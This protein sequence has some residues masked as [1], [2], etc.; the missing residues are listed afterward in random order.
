M[1]TLLTKAEV[2]TGQDESTSTKLKVV[3][4][5]RSCVHDGAGL[6][7][8]IFF[9]G[10][11]LRCLWC[12][13]PEA[14]SLKSNDGDMNISIESIAEIILR[15]KKY[16][17]VSGG[18]VTLSGG[19]P[20]LQDGE[21]LKNLLRLL[22]E[23][24]IHISAETALHAPWE[25]ISAVMPY[26]DTFIVD[27]KAVGSDEFHKSLTG[28]DG[29]LIRSN[30]EKLLSS[31]AKIKIRML[32]VPELNDSEEHIKNAASYIKSLGFN[33]IELM[34]YHSMYENKAHTFG[35]DIPM[36]NITPGQSLISLKNGVELFKKYAVDAYSDDLM[37]SPA[38][39]ELAVRDTAT[40]GN[41]SRMRCRSSRK[42]RHRQGSSSDARTT[43]EDTGT[44]TAVT[45]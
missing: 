3:R 1:K 11:G 36:L 29:V 19:E 7:T 8:T 22:K 14:L 23:H 17:Q 28:Q 37:E 20:F 39:A 5:Q 26:I 42:L 13:N 21:S 45:R 32:M 2:Q 40:S 38:A 27:L 24:S 10:C 9:R 25:S 12:Q 15:D 6:R 4:L 16:Y 43:W 33:S 35:L 30:L 41:S 44:S 31:K 18:G 34:K